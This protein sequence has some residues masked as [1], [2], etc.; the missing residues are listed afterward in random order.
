MWVVLL[1]LPETFRRWPMVIRLALLRR[2]NLRRVLMLV[3]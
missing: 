1:G 3:P 2:F